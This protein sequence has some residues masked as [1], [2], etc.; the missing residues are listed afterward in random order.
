[1]LATLLVPTLHKMLSIIKVSIKLIKNVLDIPNRR[2]QV[3][4]QVAVYKGDQKYKIRERYLLYL[5]TAQ[6]SFL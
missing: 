2:Y 3:L 1:M 5:S 4:R 6:C